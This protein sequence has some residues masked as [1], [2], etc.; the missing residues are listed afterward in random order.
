MSAVEGTEE[1]ALG[2][3]VQLGPHKNA[4]QI[5]TVAINEDGEPLVSLDDT[6]EVTGQESIRILTKSCNEFFNKGRLAKESMTCLNLSGCETFVPMFDKYNARLGGESFVDKLKSGFMVVVKAII[7]Y[8]RKVVDWI[9][10][11]VKSL[12]GFTKTKK[13]ISANQVYAD[14]LARQV[15]S[16]IFSA[17]ES[18]GVS[19][20]DKLRAQDYFYSL[21]SHVTG[22]E[23]CGIIVKRGEEASA[24]IKRLSEAGAVIKHAATQVYS[25]STE[26]GKIRSDYNH[27]MAEFRRGVGEGKLDKAVVNKLTESLNVVLPQEVVNKALKAVQ[28]MSKEVYGIEVNGKG[29]TTNFRETAKAIDGQL[30]KQQM[31]LTRDSAKMA[32]RIAKDLADRVRSEPI[33]MNAKA[34]GEMGILID[35]KDAELIRNV[36]NKAESV[37]HLIGDYLAYCQRV[38]MYAEINNYCMEQL[39]RTEA[40][41]ASVV[42]WHSKLT[43]I[44]S[45]YLVRDLEK[46]QKWHDEN[47]LYKQE[48][49]EDP[50]KTEHGTPLLL[51]NQEDI[52]R[53]MHPN[54]I[55][56]SEEFVYA[57]RAFKDLPNVKK[58]INNLLRSLGVPMKV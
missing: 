18:G 13:E 34:I 8:V 1:V 9:V 19:E 11:R 17:S 26:I 16:L 24:G 43:A 31:A 33:G 38:S 36:A 50:F 49:E 57:F 47:K 37:T 27:A 40:T 45:A 54:G 48:H 29:W 56:F 30:G 53:A 4:D 28:D 21:P 42:S 58:A 12:F 5:R 32:T 44:A 3:V 35:E 52:N 20:E 7:T 46:I 10:V 2:T 39:Q 15:A 22:K 6:Y 25:L 23:A 55:G 41:V 14:E 51:L